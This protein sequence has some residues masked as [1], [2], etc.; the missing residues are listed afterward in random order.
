M[1]VGG[2]ATSAYQVEDGTDPA[3]SAIDGADH[4]KSINDFVCLTD[5]DRAA[6][7]LL[8]GRERDIFR[9]H[10][11]KAQTLKAVAAKHGIGFQRVSKIAR[12]ARGKIIL[13]TDYVIENINLR[14]TLPQWHWAEGWLDGLRRCN[15]VELILTRGRRARILAD[16]PHWIHGSSP[17][18]GWGKVLPLELANRVALRRLAEIERKDINKGRWN[19][20][21][22]ARLKIKEKKERWR[23]RKS[24]A[25]GLWDP[26]TPFWHPPE[27]DA[28]R[29][30]PV[31]SVTPPWLGPVI[32]ALWATR[33]TYPAR[34]HVAAP[35]PKPQWISPSREWHFWLDVIERKKHLTPSKK[36]LEAR[37][38]PSYYVAGYRALWKKKLEPDDWR[39]KY[40]RE[41]QEE[42]LLS[43]Q[44]RQKE[45]A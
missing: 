25:P 17:P 4:G 40:Q 11:I 41:R 37:S 33:K 44:P 10:Y 1:A 6:S 22:I 20:A 19:R 21:L 13:A 34:I 14:A 42:F 7:S 32:P 27:E 2:V 35:P 36:L 45:A 12:A 31:Y 5:L 15:D 29:I 43:I 26:L 38:R 24:D 8:R 28:N 30:V 23:K 39:I 16:L 3:D 18:L 9:A